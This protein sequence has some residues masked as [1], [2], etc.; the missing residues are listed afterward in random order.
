[1]TTR[2]GWALKIPELAVNTIGTAA[3]LCSMAS[4]TP[5]IL[6][7][8]REKDASSVSLRMFILTVTGFALWTTYGLMLGSWPVT[9]SNAVCL[10]LSG[11][12][13]GLRWKFRDA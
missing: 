5:Q 1:M 11:V 10:I 7:I 8:W 6:K 9:V 3:A 4:F 12:V 2:E 13:L